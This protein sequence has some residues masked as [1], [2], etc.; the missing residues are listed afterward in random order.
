MRVSKLAI[1][2]LLLL[3]S[4]FSY[5]QNTTTDLT[6]SLEEVSNKVS[7]QNFLVRENALRVY[8]AK[9]R[10]EVARAE[11]IPKLNLWKIVGIIFN[12]TSIVDN[13]QDIA[14]FLVPNNWFKIKEEKALYFVQREGYRA[15]W[16]NEIMTA[17]ALF[18]HQMMDQALLEHILRSQKELQ[19]LLV[20]INT[21]I[22]FGGA[23]RN[24]AKEIRVRILDLQEDQR[25]LE[26]LLSEEKSTL[27]YVMGLTTDIKFQ[28]APVKTPDFSYLKPLSAKEFEYR[29]VDSSPE[30]RQFD[31]LLK[32]LSYIKKQVTFS[33]LG[34]ASMSR[35][36][37]G[38]VFDHIPLQD[39]LGAGTP[40][41][42]KITKAEKQILE[43]QKQGAM[44]TVK[45]NLMLLVG[46][47]NLDIK[48]YEGLKERTELTKSI[49]DH[50]YEKLSLGEEV[51]SLALVEASR[52]HIKADSAF[53][54]VQY[55]FMA[56]EDKLNR[57]LFYKDYAKKPIEFSLEEK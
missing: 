20:A 10:I 26:V 23:D 22:E 42:Q 52:N 29:A 2:F 19:G 49:L 48:N 37:G 54:A 56:N 38:G 40:V 41:I 12:P 8:Q 34:V 3:E 28:L 24:D 47:Y 4:T 17:K 45:R 51:E 33:F 9:Q 31:Y 25:S 57:I 53:Y 7:S 44:E 55:R 27:A 43:L 21:K 39:G 5:A 35:G 13:I 50:L 36:A 6:I 30:V 1:T 14:P 11:R 15:L 16:A 32:A 46:N 18:F